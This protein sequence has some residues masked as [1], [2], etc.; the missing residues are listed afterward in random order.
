[1]EKVFVAKRVANKLVSTEAAVDAAIVEVGEMMAELLQARKDLN[2]SATFGHDVSVKVADAMQALIAART[3]MVDAHAQLEEL[4][5]GLQI[6]Q[7]LGAVTDKQ[8][9]HIVVSSLSYM[10]SNSFRFCSW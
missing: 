5:K 10:F 6:L 3:A 2:L 9:V 4:D 8:T 1:M 7:V